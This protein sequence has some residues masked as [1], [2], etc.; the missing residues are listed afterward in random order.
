MKQSNFKKISSLCTL[1]LKNL[2]AIIGSVFPR[3]HVWLLWVVG[4][5]NWCY[6]HIVSGRHGGHLPFHNTQE[7]PPRT[8]IYPPKYKYWWNNFF[9]EVKWKWCKFEYL[10][11]IVLLIECYIQHCLIRSKWQTVPC[12][13]K[14][15]S[16]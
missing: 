13:I 15:S 6:G 7:H 5:G 11:I 16:Q 4:V 2:K 9:K 14:V 10:R 8:K 1:C 12:I 3:E